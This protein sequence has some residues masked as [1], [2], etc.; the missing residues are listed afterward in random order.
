MKTSSEV[1]EIVQ[2]S[3]HA[4]KVLREDY[5]I[6]LFTGPSFSSYSRLDWF[7]I[8]ELHGDG[9]LSTSASVPAKFV[10]IAIRPRWYSSPSPSIPA[11]HHPNPRPSLAT[12]ILCML[13]KNITFFDKCYL[14]MLQELKPYS[15]VVLQFNSIYCKNHSPSTEHPRSCVCCSLMVYC[16]LTPIPQ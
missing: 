6:F 5:T 1:A 13:H 15:V 8:R 14:I 10:S 11:N 3:C 16:Q 2:D 12:F 9:Y 4:D 7:W